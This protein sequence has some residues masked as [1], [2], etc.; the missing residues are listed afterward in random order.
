MYN[1][2]PV[3]NLTG[4]N[5]LQEDLGDTWSSYKLAITPENA[6]LMETLYN[7]IVITDPETV[8]GLTI[9]TIL[10][11]ESLDT[12]QQKDLL[13]D[14]FLNNIIEMLTKFG[15]TLDMD[16]VEPN[17]LRTLYEITD[18]LYI[19]DNYEDLQSISE[20]LETKDLDPKDRFIE[21]FRKIHDLDPDDPK[22]E[23]LTYLILECTE[24]LMETLRLGL[25]VL[26]AEPE[27]P[28]YVKLRV[29]ANRD[30]LENTVAVKHVRNNGRLGMGFLSLLNFYAN[31]LETAM[32]ISPEH[33]VKEL[34]GF[35]LISETPNDV[36]W[37]Q[38]KQIIEE[39]ISDLTL[40]FKAE[41]VAEKIKLPEPENHVN[42]EG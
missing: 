32:Q 9:S 11:D 40:I 12:S 19:I 27:I 24:N 42:D 1:E 13:F 14:I 3:V 16:Y 26:D 30:F 5:L 2:I 23:D 15:I 21:L 37:D 17:S 39:N 18:I 20:L 33:Y 35:V 25:I 8:L 29:L 31:E 34:F 38:L 4:V 22:L 28:E 10:I 41:K 36:F 6:E 7:L